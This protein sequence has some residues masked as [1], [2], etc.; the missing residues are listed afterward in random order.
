M[1]SPPTGRLR[2]NRCDSDFK[3]HCPF[4]HFDFDKTSHNHK[5]NIFADQQRDLERQM[6]TSVDILEASRN[7]IIKLSKLQTVIPH[8]LF[9]QFYQIFGE[10]GTVV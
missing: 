4:N 7:V 6:K 1:Q 2:G 8:D 9:D 10:D 3:A 5:C